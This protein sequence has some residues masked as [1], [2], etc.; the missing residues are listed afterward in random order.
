MKGDVSSLLIK[1][2]CMLQPC[3]GDFSVLRCFTCT[4]QDARLEKKRIFKKDF[5]I[6][7]YEDFWNTREIKSYLLTHFKNDQFLD[8]GVPLESPWFMAIIHKDMKWVK[9]T[10]AFGVLSYENSCP[11]SSTGRVK[12]TVFNI[13]DF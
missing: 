10:T 7:L 1:G 11:T 3:L 6:Y 4:S 8:I 12:M 9:S 2:P 5:W 13:N